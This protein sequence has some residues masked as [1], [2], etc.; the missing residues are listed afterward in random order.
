[1]K[2]VLALLLSLTLVIAMFTGCGKKNETEETTTTPTEAPVATEAPAETEEP[3]ATEAPATD[4]AGVKT[5]LAIVSNIAKSKDAAE[6]DGT[7]EAYS[8]AAAVLVG[9][10]GKILDCK[11]DA[12]QSKVNFSKEGKVT[13]DL[14]TV[15]K[16]K[17]ELGTEYGMLKASSIGK[18]WNEQANA[19]AAYVIGKTVDEV[20][21]IAVNEEGATTDADLAASVTIKL[22]DY[23][24][25]IEKAVASAQELGAKEGDKLGLAITSDISGSTDAT[26]DA[27]GLAKAYNYYSAVSVGA[28]GKITS[29]VLD[30]SIVEVNFDT[31]GKL[32]TDLASTFQSKQELKDAYG[33]KKASAIGK[34]WYEQANAF[35]TYATGKTLDEVNGITITEDGHAGDADLA[36][37]VTVHVGDFV[38]VINKGVTNAQ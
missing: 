27:A 18:E 3:A 33:M 38:E 5:G 22:G 32:T 37:S 21:G 35:A 7:A 20:K 13:T 1:M 16:T 36:S 25:G 24:A 14:A 23:I 10:D 8:I 9:A 34:E 12:I 19:F 17:Q 26:A 11:L 29:T 6:E 15:F 4:A 2:K 28:D 31:T 30:A